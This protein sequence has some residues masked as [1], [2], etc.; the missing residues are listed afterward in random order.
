MRPEARRGAHESFFSGKT[1]ENI[2]FSKNSNQANMA[3]DELLDERAGLAGLKFVT[4]LETTKRGVVVDRYHFPPQDTDF[5]EHDEGFEPARARRRFL[6]SRAG[7]SGVPTSRH[8]CRLVQ[9]HAPKSAAA[10]LVPARSCVID[11]HP[12]HQSR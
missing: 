4:R 3:E 8:Q 11:K 10:F 6:H 2:Q 9:S 12:P 7:G 5:E 1:K